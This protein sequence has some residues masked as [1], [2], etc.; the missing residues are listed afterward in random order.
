MVWF[1]SVDSK[2]RNMK[3]KM[4]DHYSKSNNGNSSELKKNYKAS[5]SILRLANLT[6][7]SFCILDSYATINMKMRLRHKNWL[8]HILPANT[9]KRN[10][11]TS[12]TKI[13][14]FIYL[15]LQCAWCIKCER[16]KI[17]S[18]FFFFFDKWVPTKDLIKL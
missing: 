8:V 13:F 3:R 7:L 14:F 4:R 6:L 15:R 10:G 16:L 1:H 5:K 2:V 12:Q 11:A 18:N 9:I 17:N